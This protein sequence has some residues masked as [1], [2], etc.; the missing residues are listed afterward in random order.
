METEENAGVELITS[1]FAT[2]NRFDIITNDRQNLDTQHSTQTT[3]PAK[4]QKPPPFII[5]RRPTNSKSL[6]DGLRT[7]FGP[8]QYTIQFTKN[9]III[10]VSNPK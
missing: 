3:Q 7:K 5:E 1:A 9:N 2:S 10:Q 4:Q 6:I 8:T